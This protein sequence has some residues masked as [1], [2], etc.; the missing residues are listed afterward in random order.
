M[1]NHRDSKDATGRLTAK[2]VVGQPS[3]AIKFNDRVDRAAASKV[4]MPKPPDPRLRVQRI[5]RQDSVDSS[6]ARIAPFERSRTIRS[7]MNFRRGDKLTACELVSSLSFFR[8][9]ER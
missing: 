2:G 5:V 9:G 3:V 7:S 1:P 6:D 8:F 4:S